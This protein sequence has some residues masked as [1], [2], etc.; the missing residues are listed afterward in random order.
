MDNDSEGLGQ[1]LIR[2]WHTIALTAI[3]AVMLSVL[4]IL[5]AK[6]IYTSTANLRV[7]PVE[8]G[9]VSSATSSNNNLT[10][11]Y[12]D[13]L[14]TE[15]AVIR[16]N[17]VVALA[18]DSIRD[19]KTLK[20]IPHPLDYVRNKLV[21]EPSKL[22]R[23]ID[24]SFESHSQD[25]SDLIVDSVIKA[26]KD[27]E[28]QAWKDKTQD[29][30]KVLGD[31]NRQA[32][33]ELSRVRDRL[34]TLAMENG[35]RP[36]TDPQ[37][38][39]QHSAVLSL[40]DAKD[41]AQLETLTAH[42]AYQQ[43]A[44]AI[45][46]NVDLLRR[47]DEAEMH[48]NFST[49]PQEDLKKYQGELAIEQAKLTDDLRSFGPSHP[50]IIADQARVS[51]MIVRTVVAAKE[52]EDNAQ[53]QQDSIEKSLDLAVKAEADT[54]DAIREYSRLQED[55]AR[56]KGMGDQLDLRS[57]DLAV[58]AVVGA[59]TVEPLS[60]D[61]AGDIKPAKIKTLAIGTIL[62]LIGGL[63][64][65]CV[66]DW[67]DDRMRSALAVRNIVGAPV[68]GAIPAITTAY[69]AADRG[70]IVHHEPFGMPAES[71]RTM[72]TALQY[73]LPPNTRTILITS[74]VAG[75]GKST[76]VSNLGIAF[77]QASK[78]VLIID[79]DLRAPMQHRLFGLKDRVG[80]SSVLGGADTLEQAI[81]TTE[82]EG[83]DV[84]PCG[85]VPS[86]PSE[87]LNSH[88][89]TE[90]LQELADK[91]DMVLI[92]SP[93]VTAVADARILSASADVSMLVIKLDTCTRKQAE[94]AREGLRSVGA[95]LIGVALN[96]VNEPGHHGG[97]S[98]YYQTNNNGVPTL[99]RNAPRSP[100]A[101]D[102]GP[103]TRV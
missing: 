62:G 40:R 15:C 51:D 55:E 97:A 19:T 85:P 44:K 42:N 29:Y 11:D 3:A 27:Y 49:D 1:I 94:A 34:R 72:R 60:Q 88:A 87:M 67:T 64:L 56:L 37:N 96:G 89:F 91:Y 76:F 45:I 4:Y 33:E 7:A 50:V 75:D 47:V 69:T 14:E 53:T 102:L 20:G 31:S 57:H 9:N 90:H 66:R 65:A 59:V 18:M 21:A 93:P 61:V 86:N 22:G 78:R 100:Y 73:G 84:L 23:T 77:A 63:T 30:I 26:Y 46:G 6:P 38:T 32:E 103:T 80:L 28:S 25:D 43:A 95:R 68:L 101:S 58:Q 12:N 99:E 16:S 24:V 13:F 74:P 79:G 98:G 39:P 81:C 8:M 52:W 10:Q 41:K 17:Q 36:G 92:D 71:Y 2:Q 5:V 83:L 35:F 48:P 54:A 70:Q 82:I